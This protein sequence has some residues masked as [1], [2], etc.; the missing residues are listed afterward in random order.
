MI[1]RLVATPSTQP[2]TVS[3][4]A[5]LGDGVREQPLGL[6]QTSTEELVNHAIISHLDH[7]CNRGQLPT[8]RQSVWKYLV[9]LGEIRGRNLVTMRFFEVLVK[10]HGFLSAER[11]AKPPSTFT[12]NGH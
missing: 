2:P 6:H 5:S 12:H 11:E 4:P 9:T 10:V 3:G 7:Y 8:C 1:M